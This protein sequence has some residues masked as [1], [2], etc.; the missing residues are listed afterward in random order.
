[1]TDRELDEILIF[2]WPKV[3]RTAMTGT[4]DWLKSF[5][6]SIARNGKRASWRPSEKQAGIMRRLVADM[7]AP[8]EP[9]L[10]LIEEDDAA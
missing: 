9:E 10:T 6:R 1:M 2:W 3:L 8:A 5:A 7:G 4:D